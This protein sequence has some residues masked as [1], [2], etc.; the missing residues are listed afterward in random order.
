MDDPLRAVLEFPADNFA[1]LVY[2]DWLEER[3]D[4][5]ARDRAKFIRA[6]VALAELPATECHKKGTST[7]WATYTPW[8]RCPVCKLRMAEYYSG[9]RYITWDWPREVVQPITEQQVQDIVAAGGRLSEAAHVQTAFERG[10]INAIRLPLDVF[11]E[12]AERI[13]GLCPVERVDLTD[14][15]PF[16]PGTRLRPFNSG[17]HRWGWTSE[18]DY[19]FGAQWVLPHGIFAH[20]ADTDA[21]LNV[22]ASRH[23]RWYTSE[24]RARGALSVACVDWGREKAGL[25]AGGVGR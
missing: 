15:G 9:R 7:A 24:S 11:H 17:N 1:R 5:P 10:F 4:R 8:C 23:R 18:R 12:H 14:Q 19:E 2:A 16:N 13:F 22:P 20:L 3:G 6:Q 25:G 21:E